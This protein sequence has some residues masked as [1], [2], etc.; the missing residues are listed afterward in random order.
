MKLLS[1][2]GRTAATAAL[3]VGLAGCGAALDPQGTGQ[4]VNAM[5]NA[6]AADRAMSALTKGDYPAAERHATLALRSNPKDATALLVAG[7]AHQGMGRYDVARQ[8]FE[9]IVTTQPAGTIMT[10]GDGGVI[11]P[12]S[13]V[14]VARAN[15][16][17]IDKITGRNIP[18]SAAES[19]RP[20]GA[21][22]IGAPPF[23]ANEPVPGISDRPVVS[24]DLAP[25][26][27][28][29]GQAS[30]AER[31]VAGR[32][33]ILQ[34]LRD[35][36][37]ITPQEYSARRGAN[38]GALLPFTQSPPAKGLERPIPGEAAV[39]TRLR[40]LAKTLENRGITAE[41]LA[42]ERGAILEALLPEKPRGTEASPLPP[43]DLIE[44][45]KAVGRLERM[46]A[47]GLVTADEAAREK[48]ALDRAL[49]RHLASQLVSGTA[50]GLRPASGGQPGAAPASAGSAK[51]AG[52]G[53]SLAWGK[54]E[55]AAR[56]SWDRIKGKF[57]VELGGLEASI[58]RI[59]RKGKPDSWQVVAGPV[60]DKA[61]ASKLCK[62]LKLHRQACDPATL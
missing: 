12:R 44:A 40:D 43:K 5:A 42:A 39:V 24:A 54:S 20:P 9:V 38:V 14:E 50:T 47:A 18:R 36:G 30:E 37:L 28:G 49:D 2:L 11:M 48:T 10:P 58:K 15:M 1:C 22:A 35:E 45:G 41:Q 6:G 57:P 3:A 46:K 27:G 4:A 19:G 31:N 60:A 61:A 62:T 33:R 25:L 29:A 32:F 52:W 23:P 51:A 34:R 16:A 26:D 21:P 13:V 17:V 55:E 56:A 7:L 59:S 53:V 8:Y